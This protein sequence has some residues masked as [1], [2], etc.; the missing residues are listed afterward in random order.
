MAGR[1]R[2]HSL[3]LT[4][5]L[6]AASCLIGGCATP[7]PRWTELIEK[8]EIADFDRSACSPPTA[9]PASDDL[10]VYLDGSASM[11][12]YVN[13]KGASAYRETLRLLT[14]VGPL[15]EPKMRIQFR[16]VGGTVDPP[17]P[18]EALAP[19]PDREDFYT[20]PETD[21]AAA[22]RTFSVNLEGKRT[23]PPPRMHI[24]VTDGVQSLGSTLATNFRDECL[25]LLDGADGRPPWQATVFGVRSQFNG[26][27]YSEVDRSTVV[28]YQSEEDKA[29]WRPFYLIVFSSD[30]VRHNDNVARL[31]REL[32]KLESKP[33]VHELPLSACFTS[34]PPE[35]EV[36]GDE[37]GEGLGPRVARVKH[38]RA[39]APPTFN[40]QIGPDKNRRLLIAIRPAWSEA[41]LSAAD[42]VQLAEML[43]W[44]V[45]P[46]YPAQEAPG[47]G[48]PLLTDL[49]VTMKNGLVIAS[50]QP[51]WESKTK[52]P[53]WRIFR[54][55]GRLNP[56]KRLPAWLEAW[57][58]RDDR[59]IA[60]ANRTYNLL[61]TWQGSWERSPIGKQFVADVYLAVG[62]K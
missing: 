1:M 14:E 62:P 22:V 43:D 57:N 38:K 50:L 16:K 35:V 56:K 32:T 34:G 49:Q 48:Y 26:K 5:M 37:A 21:L 3:T 42:A 8:K 24:L 53:A 60:Q 17:K 52:K 15:C 30:G 44:D 54:L 12:G 6:C 41:A 9:A 55:T 19:S 25:K 61:A 29:T 28:T 36:K 45:T 13:P 18:W 39:D 10:I 27:V 59:T 11:R 58:T 51:Q 46:V 33:E 23:G 31:R 47:I 20:L 40:I 4:L 2:R 7:P